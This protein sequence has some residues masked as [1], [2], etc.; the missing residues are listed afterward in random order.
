VRL[1]QVIHNHRKNQFYNI[2]IGGDALG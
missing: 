2:K 1:H